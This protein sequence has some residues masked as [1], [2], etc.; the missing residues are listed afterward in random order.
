[1]HIFS[2]GGHQTLGSPVFWVDTSPLSN[3]LTPN[4]LYFNMRN[5]NHPKIFKAFTLVPRKHRSGVLTTSPSYCLTVPTIGEVSKEQVIRSNL[6][7]PINQA[8]K[9]L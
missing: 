8:L 3:I 2:G 7:P 9:S 1:M 5:A 4:D 6:L